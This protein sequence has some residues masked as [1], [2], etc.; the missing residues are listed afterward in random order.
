MILNI[1]VRAALWGTEGRP[2]QVN[3]DC[4]DAP[5]RAVLD[6]HGA[7]CFPDLLNFLLAYNLPET[8]QN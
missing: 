7:N 4:L 3:D 1:D 2:D 6:R 5:P 8:D